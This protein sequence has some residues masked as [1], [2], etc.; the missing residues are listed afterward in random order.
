MIEKTLSW[1]AG[2]N[3][4]SDQ[5]WIEIFDRALFYTSRTPETR[6]PGLKFSI[7]LEH[8]DRLCKIQARF[9]IFD[10]D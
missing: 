7:A 3:I 10:Q 5:S 6:P 4:S 8:F 2:L 1:P 9:E